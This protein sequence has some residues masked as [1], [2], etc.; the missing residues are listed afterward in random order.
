MNSSHD[1]KNIRTVLTDSKEGASK[2]MNPKIKKSKG[3]LY[4]EKHGFS[5]VFARNVK[6]ST[7]LTLNSPEE[8]EE[9]LKLY[10]AKRSAR[11]KAHRREQQ[12]A[13]EL[14]NI[15]MRS[16]GKQRTKKHSHRKHS[17]ASIKPYYAPKSN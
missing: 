3:Q 16:K 2:V 12:K 15:Y 4:K 9:A 10:K 1:L 7:G 6:R 14:S 5:K 17:G 13:H 8:K 11:K